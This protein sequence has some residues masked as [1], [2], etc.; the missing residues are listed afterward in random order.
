MILK[1]AHVLNRIYL[2]GFTLFFSFQMLMAPA[3]VY[4]KP[5]ESC[6]SQSKVEFENQFRRL[7]VDHVLWTS[8][9]ITSA[10]TADAKD[11]K[12]VLNRLLKN[13]EDIGNSLKP[14]YGE[15][16]GNELTT[17]LKEHIVLAGKIVEAAKQKDEPLVGQLT[18][19]W[20]RNADQ[21]ADFLSKANPYLKNDELKQLLRT[22]LTLV[23]NDLVSSLE[24]N[25]D[26]RIASIDEG[27]SHIIMMSDV[28]SKAVEKQFPDAFN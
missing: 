27:V 11:Q 19:E 6:I 2:Y 13:Q 9:Y 10:T 28:I 26:G 23:T 15:K 17:L 18:K 22:H 25:W 16:A 3:N 24:K 12:Q 8:N 20:N 1:G 7:W 21:I 4:A 5:Q 14:L